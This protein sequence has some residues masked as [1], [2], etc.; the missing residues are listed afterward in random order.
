MSD[1]YSVFGQLPQ[2]T[3]SGKTRNSK[4]IPVDKE[5]SRRKMK[6]RKSPES[7]PEED[8]AKEMG[9]EEEEDSP[10]GKVLDITI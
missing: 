4:E 2:M 7:I 8:E 6:R 10:S 1:D 9:P 3:P 5:S